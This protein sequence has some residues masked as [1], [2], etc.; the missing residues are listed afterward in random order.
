[1]LCFLE[2]D[3]TLGVY[4]N[5]NGMFNHRM[6]IDDRPQHYRVVYVKV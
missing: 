2:D 5:I 4:A 6:I 1:M 3:Q